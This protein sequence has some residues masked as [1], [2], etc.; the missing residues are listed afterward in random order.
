MIAL[1]GAHTIGF[2]H[3]NRFSN[4]IFGFS[5][6]NRITARKEPGTK[7]RQHILSNIVCDF[8]FAII[9]VSR[10]YIGL[11]LLT[12]ATEA[13]LASKVIYACIIT[14]VEE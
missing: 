12:V 10:V 4:R 13:S 7:H 1:S 6:T 14:N 2:S 9:H 8:D 5:R 11:C 3:C